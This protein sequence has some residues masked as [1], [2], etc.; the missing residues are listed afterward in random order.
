[1]AGKPAY[2]ASLT[3]SNVRC[4]GSPQTI[5]LSDDRGRPCPWTIILGDNGVGKTTLLQALAA[6]QPEPLRSSSNEVEEYVVTGMGGPH[7]PWPGNMFSFHRSGTDSYFVE[8]EYAVGARLTESRKSYDK[9]TGR[10]DVTR[11]KAGPSSF[12][13]HVLQRK[14]LENLVCYA[15]GAARRMG[16]SSLA[17]GG[18]D[19]RERHPVECLWADDLELINAEEWLLQAEYNANKASKIQKEARKRRD[20]IEDILISVLPDVDKIRCPAP[21]KARDRPRVEFHTP[22]G[23]VPID[24]LGLGYKSMISWVVD[25]ASRLFE[26]YPKSPNPIAEPA[27]VLVDEVDLHLH[28]SWQRQLT[29]YLSD[30]FKETQFIVTAHSPLIVQASEHANIAVLRRNGDEVEID[31]TVKTVRGWRIDQILT[32]D[33][34]GLP[35]ARS[36][37]LDEPIAERRK[38]LSKSRLT[39]R[40][41]DRLQELESQIGDLPG[42]ES[43]EDAE[44]ME[45]VR[46]AAHRLRQRN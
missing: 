5:N 35:T 4:F 14:K 40:D 19:V 20:E 26:R 31:Q 21:E 45:I 18:G 37:E 36:P 33:I 38:I 25:L 1:M 11:R 29:R 34:F 6:S 41:R 7:V 9:L 39:K 12:S 46:K 32:S 28:P 16:R 2:Y 30:R 13:G 22:Y 17:S 42:A 15:Y 44:A 8:A 43:L 23:W 10:V 3:L 24:A 27:V